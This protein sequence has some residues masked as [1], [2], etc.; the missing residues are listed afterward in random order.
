DSIAD[1]FARGQIASAADEKTIP[2][3]I[4][5]EGITAFVK[6]SASD[7]KEAEV[8]SPAFDKTL[9]DQAHVT[10]MEIAETPQLTAEINNTELDETEN[11]EEGAPAD[12][13]PVAM[14]FG[15]LDSILKTPAS[16]INADQLAF[17][18]F[19]SVDYFASQG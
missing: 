16:E 18:P 3:D 4:E 6:L 11:Q 10:D 12:I 7:E 8:I 15:N 19:H 2:Q 9:P 14:P 13:L 1:E 17:E 5:N